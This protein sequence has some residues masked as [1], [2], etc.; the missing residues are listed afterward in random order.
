MNYDEAIATL[1]PS[2]DAAFEAY[3]ALV[4][5]NREQV[6]RVRD[7]PRAEGGDFWADR[8]E[9]FRPGVLP[10]DE[11]PHLVALSEPGDSW[12]DIGAGGGRFA[13]PLSEHVARLVAVEPSP[14]MREVLTQSAQAA[15]RANIKVVDLHW[16]PASPEQAPRADVSLAAN[17]LYD[18]PDLRGFLD[19]MEAVSGRLCV[20]ITS[21]RAPSTPN[22]ELWHALYEEPL[23]Q[24]P[25]LRELVAVLGALGRRY[26]VR[27]TPMD[28]P[29]RPLAVDEALTELRWRLW[30]QPG[31]PRDDRLREEVIARFSVPSGEIRLPPQR[32]Y[33][34]VVSWPPPSPAS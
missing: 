23:R 2:A 31:T 9:R 6:E 3:A 5:A 25:A 10:A 14:A 12:L 17:V 22:A 30:T 29:A 16:P 1:R 19:A 24:L 34:A 4:A 20:I 28:A 8:A 32:N 13:V 26:E 11:L 7:R 33:S 18:A 21:D 27:L 15:G